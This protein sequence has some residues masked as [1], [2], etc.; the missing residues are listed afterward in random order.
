[1]QLIRAS[2]KP[3]T[4]SK[5][6]TETFSGTVHMDPIFTAEDCMGNNVCFIPGARTYWHHHERG[7][8]LT[9]TMGSGLVCSEGQAPR[10]LQVGDMVH[11]PPGERH[12]HGGTN[13]TCMAHTAI[14]LGSKWDLFSFSFAW[15]LASGSLGWRDA[16]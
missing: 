11:V 2:H 8:I 3:D 4:A 1:M 6:P 13:T 14:S 16:D 7:Q 12:W 5:Q 9:V 10:K 15:M